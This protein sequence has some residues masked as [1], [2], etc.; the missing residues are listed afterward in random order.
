MEQNGADFWDTMEDIADAWD[1]VWDFIDDGVND[2]L[3]D[4][5]G[6]EWTLPIQVSSKEDFNVVVHC[7]DSDSGT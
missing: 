1:D 5:Y 3:D 6:I 4:L 2:V 7:T